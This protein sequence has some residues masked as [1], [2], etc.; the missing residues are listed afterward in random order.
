MKFRLAA[1]APA[2]ALA[3]LLAVPSAGAGQEA[4]THT[5]VI[6]FNDQGELQYSLDPVIAYPGDR[7]VFRAVGIQSWTITFPDGTPF[8]ERTISAT[9]DQAR[10]MPI[11]PNAAVRSYAYDVSAT[12]NG[13]TV[14]EDPEIIVR[15]RGNGTPPVF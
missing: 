15:D 3:A 13:E 1:L 2:V 4:T 5:V 8:S 7:V 10:T 14:I 11:L 6:S 12:R 9:G